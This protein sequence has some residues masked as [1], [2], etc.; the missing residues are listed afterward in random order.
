VG[1]IKELQDIVVQ[2]KN[3]FDELCALYSQQNLQLDKGLYNELIT[4]I[5]CTWY[6]FAPQGRIAAFGDMKV[7]D[8]ELMQME[9]HV[10][11]TH[12]KTWAKYGFQALINVEIA[13]P[14]L[15]LYCN[16]RSCATENGF[17]TSPFYTDS[18]YLFLEWDGEQMGERR[19][20]DLVT[21]FFRKFNLHMNTTSIRS[22]VETT[23]ERMKMEGKIST[24][25]RVAVQG[26]NGHS[27]AVTQAHYV[28]QS[29]R[30]NVA[31]ARN[32]LTQQDNGSVEEGDRNA[33]IE[34]LDRSPQQ[35][36][37]SFTQHVNTTTC[38]F[39]PYLE[40]EEQDLSTFA[41]AAH[42]EQPMLRPGQIPNISTPLPS[43]NGD[44]DTAQMQANESRTEDSNTSTTPIL[45][46]LSLH[47]QL[48]L[49]SLLSQI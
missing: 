29:M 6:C 9:G 43:R 36:P 24:A 8:S 35:A 34:V 37:N 5:M 31:K 32:I 12:F 44:N 7:A 3:S 13:V 42:F 40:S 2:R 4:L 38:S 30:E 46:P 33:Q 26:I 39:L 49:V 28:K 11:S 48:Y 15:E 1:G 41:L 20:G 47:T 23:A 19:L 14:L 22:L 45:S 25:V 21:S 10:M 16:W 27:D 18:G 17:A